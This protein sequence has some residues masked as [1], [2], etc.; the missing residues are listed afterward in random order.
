MRSLMTMFV[1]VIVVVV[2]GRVG[3]GRL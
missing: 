3:H 1:I 2:V